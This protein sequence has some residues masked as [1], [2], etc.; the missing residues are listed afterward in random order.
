MR[1][2]DVTD[3]DRASMSYA[4]SRSSTTSPV[5]VL[6]IQQQRDEL[7]QRRVEM[8]GRSIV[9]AGAGFEYG[10]GDTLYALGLKVIKTYAVMM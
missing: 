5:S 7:Y 6:D 10:E 4:P 9:V 8:S 2:E 3:E 1:L